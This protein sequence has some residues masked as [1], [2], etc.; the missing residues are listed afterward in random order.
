[1]PTAADTRLEGLLSW[2]LSV[3][4]RLMR[5]RADAHIA[6]AGPT[7]AQGL[8]LL[9]RLSEGDGATQIDLARLQRVE[10]P[11]MCRMVDRLE[12][13]GLVE[14]RPSTSDRRA[15]HVHLTAAGRA[16]AREGAVL[17]AA[18]D[19]EVFGV[20]GDDERRDLS[21]LLTR[22]MERLREGRPA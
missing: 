20:L 9:M 13:D 1:M 16:A 3:A 12:R 22:V 5:V 2:R 10:A 15:V 7:A 14:R 17:A 18:L 6:A 8:G 11:S 19:D 21:D 4:G